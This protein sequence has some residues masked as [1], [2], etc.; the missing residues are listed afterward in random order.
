MMDKKQLEAQLAGLPAATNEIQAQGVELFAELMR[1][2][3]G[4]PSKNDAAA[5]YCA[6]EAVD[7]AKQ[8]REGK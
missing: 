7:F 6:R 5:S 3:I 4:N 2:Y 1:S 8:L